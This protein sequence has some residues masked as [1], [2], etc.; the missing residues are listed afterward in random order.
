M[1]VLIDASNIVP[2]SG[3]FTHLKELLKNHET[4]N[5]DIIFVASSN[6]VIDELKIN[7]KKVKYLSSLFLNNGKFFRLFWQIFVINSCIKKNKCTKLFV[8]GGYFF[9]IKRCK[10][11]LLIQNILPLEKKIFLQDRL[12]LI[13]KNYLLN[14]L[15][16][17]SI[18]R[19]DGIVLL[20][21]Y[22]KKFLGKEKVKFTVI[23]HGIQQKFFR[24]FK[25]KKDSNKKFK[26][27]YVSKYEKYKNQLN[28]VKACY[29]LK[30]NNINVSLTLYGLDREKNLLNS[31]LYKF[32]NKVNLEFKDLIIIK[33][34]IK[35]KNLINIYQ[36]FDL[37]VY[38]SKCEAFGLI[39]LETIASSL[40][41]VCSNY[42]VY[43]EI[44]Q[45][46]TVYFDPDNPLDIAESIKI[47][48]INFK[49]KFRNTKNL[50]KIAKKF[51]WKTSSNKTF[52]F[53][54]K[55]S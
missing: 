49:T 43:K 35:H 40:P 15:Y 38:P 48:I 55:L 8:L 9:F 52:N 51:S 10:V 7:N 17:F 53:I 33:N 23:P 22:S 39:I 41:I 12:I 25:K 27:L 4:K 26:I 29:E 1:N 44:L 3:G 46:N 32:I 14:L 21:K 11:I 36:K 19:S 45:R 18:W 16:R 42:P 5:Q 13:I 6:N 30:K 28:L 50:F 34:F 37:Q 24:K 47:Y 31:D 20:S 54:K 2:D